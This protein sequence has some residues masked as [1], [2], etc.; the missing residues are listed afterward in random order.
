[1]NILILLDLLQINLLENKDTNLAKSFAKKGFETTLISGPT[2]LEV[3]KQYK[4]N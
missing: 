4:I 3:N 1:M 2:N